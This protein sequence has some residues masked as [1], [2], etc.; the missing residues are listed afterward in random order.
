MPKNRRII[1]DADSFILGREICNR[2]NKQTKLQTVNDISTPCLSAF[3]D[4]KHNSNH[5]SLTKHTM[6]ITQN[7]YRNKLAPYGT[8]GRL[9]LTANFK[10]T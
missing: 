5:A 7:K 1:F 6:S 2:T 10:V 9:L 3:V 4:N 8:G